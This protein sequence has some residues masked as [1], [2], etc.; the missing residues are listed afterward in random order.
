MTVAQNGIKRL[1]ITKFWNTESQRIKKKWQ[2]FSALPLFR[3]FE[4]NSIKSLKIRCGWDIM[5]Y[6]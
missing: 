6:A 5:F 4:E 2:G 3:Q 1:D